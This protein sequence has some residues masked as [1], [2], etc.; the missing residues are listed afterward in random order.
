M[1]GH[2]NTEANVECVSQR[3]PAQPAL[4]GKQ[5]E[6][7]D[8]HGE[9]DGGVRRRPAPEHS[10][11]QPAKPE[12]MAEVRANDML[13]MDATG[14]R[15]VGGGQKRADERR[16][17]DGPAGLGH[18]GMADDEAGNNED[19]RQHERHECAHG[20]GGDHQIP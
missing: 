1:D 3:Q 18:P 5:R 17:S 20:C 14:E 9:G 2:G 13:R 7:R 8:R 4:F 6:H 15:L 12:I 19:D 16:L 11:A 10:A